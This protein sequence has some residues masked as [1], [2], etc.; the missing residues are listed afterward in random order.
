MVTEIVYYDQEIC[1]HVQDEDETCYTTYKMKFKAVKVPS[2]L[3]HAYFI[4]GTVLCKSY[5]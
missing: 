1:E 2:A 5:K 4:S 3:K